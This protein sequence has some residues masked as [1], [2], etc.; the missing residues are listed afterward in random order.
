MNSNLNTLTILKFKIINYD[1][2][3]KYLSTNKK[4]MNVK[5]KKSEFKKINNKT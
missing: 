4:T 5:N 2:K 1:S 3:N